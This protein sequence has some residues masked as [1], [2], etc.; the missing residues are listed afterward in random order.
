MRQPITG[1]EMMRT[2]KAILARHLAFRSVELLTTSEMETIIDAGLADEHEFEQVE[3]AWP[4]PG[5]TTSW[6]CLSERWDVTYSDGR[7]ELVGAHT[8]PP[9]PMSET[10]RVEREFA[11]RIH[12]LERISIRGWMPDEEVMELRRDPSWVAEFERARLADSGRASESPTPERLPTA[13]PASG[14][15]E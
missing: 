15:R 2:P 11:R 13:P 3:A 14:P 8:R 7:P 1:D 9:G 10:E 5:Q 4:R 12:V 6:T